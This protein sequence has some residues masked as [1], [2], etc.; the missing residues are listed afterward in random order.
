MSSIASKL[1]PTMD[2]ALQIP[3]GS[4]LARDGDRP[5]TGNRADEGVTGFVYTAPH[6]H[7]LVWQPGETP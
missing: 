7:T 5:G 6:R 4:E 3:C 1:A 2:R